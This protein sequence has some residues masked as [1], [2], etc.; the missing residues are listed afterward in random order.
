MPVRGGKPKPTALRMLQGNPARKPLPKH[1]AKPPSGIPQAPKHLT[2]EAREHWDEVCEPLAK[3]GLLTVIDGEALAGY[4]ESRAIY[5]EAKTRMIEEGISVTSPNGYKIPSPSF[6]VA[7]KAMKQMQSWLAEFGMTPS[8]RS[9][10]RAGEP[11]E[12][13][14]PFE[15]LLKSA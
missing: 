13:S 9:R 5:V 7:M 2:P 15:D 3:I 11:G 4:C 10:V 12:A 6:N 14:D 1:E 8:S